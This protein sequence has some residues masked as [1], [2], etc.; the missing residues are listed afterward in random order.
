MKLA[1]YLALGMGKGPKRRLEL[2]NC[3][4]KFGSRNLLDNCLEENLGP[5]IDLT[6]ALTI[7]WKNNCFDNCLDIKISPTPN[8]TFKQTSKDVV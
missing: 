3:G 1:V 2:V 5:T 4:G 6:I 8:P 7:F